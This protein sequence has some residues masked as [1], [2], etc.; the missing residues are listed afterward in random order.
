M[1]QVELNQTRPEWLNEIFPSE[2]LLNVTLKAY[3]LLSQTIVQKR[4][5]GGSFIKTLINDSKDLITGRM[6]TERKIHV[7]SGD[8]RLFVGVLK[9]LNIPVYDLPSAGAAIIFE[10]FSEN[11]NYFIKVPTA[12]MRLYYFIITI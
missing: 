7:Y 9:N 2:D 12:T 4:L 1:F 6:S 3:D 11:D 8:E 5:N 10:L